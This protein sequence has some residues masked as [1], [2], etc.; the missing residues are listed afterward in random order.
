[1]RTS[2]ARWKRS[3][4]G[5][6]AREGFRSS[7]LTLLSGTAL[8]LV[9][10]YLA[11]PILTRLFTPEQFGISDYFV[12]IASILATT[13]SLRYDD[14]V[15]LPDDE[16]GAAA[17]FWLALLLGAAFAAVV[18]AGT[19][20]GPDVADRLNVA[21]AAPWLW[22]LGPAL[23]FTRF[24]K[25]SEIWLSRHKR[26]RSI[27]TGDV[28]NKVTILGTRLGAG[29]TSTLGAGGLI[30][31][32]VAGQIVSSLFYGSVLSRRREGL[33]P[34]LQPLKALGEAARR[35]RR[36]ALFSAPAATLNAVV[37]RLPVLLLPAFFGLE[38]VGLY[39]RAFVAL[40]VPLG[41]I[42]AAVAQVFFVHATEAYRN[43]RLD[44]VTEIVHRRLVTIGMFPTA[45]LMAAGPDLFEFV[46][47]PEWRAAGAYEQY[48]A[49]WFLMS[50][51]ASPLTR[52]FDV[53]ERQRTELILSILL[54]AALVVAIVAGGTSGSANHTIRL[55]AAAGFSVRL[56][57][58][59]VLLRVANVSLR[60]A[61]APYVLH[62]GVT[63]PLALLLALTSTLVP[64]WAV[65]AVAGLSGL[66]YLGYFLRAELR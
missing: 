43:G 33:M 57:Q 25:L 56:I 29:A 35:Y 3:L 23:L 11:V 8:T 51:I 61:L 16:D 53:T 65:A 27:A 36:F 54:S 52:I 44:T 66:L 13:A 15:M 10:S 12:T 62:L 45:V 31:G 46:F 32:F 48:L 55:I 6:Y 5:I 42:G 22:A 41:L 37:T 38:I 34:R 9:L 1:M 59:A 39:G 14:A 19:L 58:I 64:P 50:V 4:E 7:V 63:I 49:P 18:S 24:S 20:W 40:A 28:A 60:A 21:A 26:F 47:G 2:A 17:V 30:G